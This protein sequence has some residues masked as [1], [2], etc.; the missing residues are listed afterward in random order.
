[1]FLV[2][3]M[4]VA[5][6]QLAAPARMDDT[7]RRQLRF[8]GALLGA[9][10]PLTLAVVTYQVPS[11]SPVLLLGFLAYAA[12]IGCVVGAWRAPAAVEAES[13]ESEAA[14]AAAVGVVIGTAILIGTSAVLLLLPDLAGVEL[15]PLVVLG[16]MLVGMVIGTAIG[17]PSAVISVWLLRRLV[18]RP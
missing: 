2:R 13:G 16:G 5:P 14:K 12:V 18:L 17:Y 4:K 10:V 8:I 3:N 15:I 7:S 9:L 11:P 1:M 6:R